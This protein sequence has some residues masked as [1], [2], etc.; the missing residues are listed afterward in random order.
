VSVLQLDCAVKPAD[1]HSR[2]GDLI[3]KASQYTIRILNDAHNKENGGPIDTF[4]IFF[5]SSMVLALMVVCGVTVEEASP[6]LE[7][8]PFPMKRLGE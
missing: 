6:A 8:L 3:D 7:D 4:P 1:V 2:Y 5:Q